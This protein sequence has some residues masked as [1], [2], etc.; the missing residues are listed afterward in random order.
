MVGERLVKE[1]DGSFDDSIRNGT[2]T[3]SA[4]GGYVTLIDKLKCLTIRKEGLILNPFATY[5][6]SITTAL[7]LSQILS[8]S[9]L[10]LID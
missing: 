10:N 6:L 2:G 9:R 1:L 5:A 8:L 4:I 3:L 7:P